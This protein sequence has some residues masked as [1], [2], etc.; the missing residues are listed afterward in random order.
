MKTSI[1]LKLELAAKVEARKAS[2]QEAIECI[3][4][5][6]E[7]KYIDSPLYEARQLDENDNLTLDAHIQYITDIYTADK[8]KVSMTFGYGVVPNKILTICKA[9]MYSKANEKAELLAMTG[10]SESQVEEITEAFGM[11]AYFSPARLEIVESTPMSANIVELLGQAATDLGLVS[12]INYGK[13]TASNTDYQYT[14]AQLRAE[15]SLENTLKYADDQLPDF[16]E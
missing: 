6:N 14:R 8:R 12:A 10:L 4:V 11:T 15:E 1:E 3:K 2:I 13:F 16:T 9:V 7:M 5:N